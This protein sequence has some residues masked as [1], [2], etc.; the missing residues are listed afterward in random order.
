MKP[1][2]FILLLFPLLLS[3]QITKPSH[4][5]FKDSTGVNATIAITTSAHPNVNTVALDVGDEIGVF[6]PSGMCCG[7][8]VWEKVNTAIRAQGDNTFTPEIDGFKDGELMLFRIWV[9]K[10]NKEYNSTVKYNASEPYKTGSFYSNGIYVLLDITGA[11]PVKVEE[12]FLPNDIE[13]SRNYPNPFN[14]STKINIFIPQRSHV[15]IDIIDINGKF[16]KNLGNSF[17]ESGN[18]IIEWNGKDNES[19]NAASGIYFYRAMIDNKVF[20][21]KMILS[22]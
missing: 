14:P 11:S 1:K 9:K 22:K 13:L 16:V 20:S 12:N 4:F 3:A 6:N 7:A 10:A 8:I 17:F 21:G 15:K 5:K 18:H 19:R 2:I